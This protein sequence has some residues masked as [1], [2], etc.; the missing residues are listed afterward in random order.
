MQFQYVRTWGIWYLC[1]QPELRTRHVRT[2]TQAR[3]MFVH[4]IPYSTIV[5][6]GEMDSEK[7]RE[8]EKVYSQFLPRWCL[9]GGILILIIIDHKWVSFFF[10]S[11]TI[12]SISY[13]PIQEVNNVQLQDL[14]AIS[15][16]E[17]FNS[18]EIIKRFLAEKNMGSEQIAFETFQHK[19]R[20]KRID[21]AS[22]QLS[23]KSFFQPKQT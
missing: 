5:L 15:W 23:I 18:C 10:L 16:K 8:I 6:R 17:C 2:S 21:A 9:L 14:P 3:T 19:L 12:V 11:F 1:N 7:R 4:Y 22:S 13:E 20:V